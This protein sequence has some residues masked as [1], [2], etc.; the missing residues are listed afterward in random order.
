MNVGE[1]KVLYSG[2][3]ETVHDN[4]GRD[5]IQKNDSQVSTFGEK[6]GEEIQDACKKG[7]GGELP[8]RSGRVFR[9]EG[10]GGGFRKKKTGGACI[11]KKEEEE[12]AL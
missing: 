5:G 3:G 7:V 8:E 2:E 11:G 1:G 4:A 10:E 9:G 6:G 12:H